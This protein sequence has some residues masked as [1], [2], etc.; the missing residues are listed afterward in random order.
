MS[1]RRSPAFWHNLHPHLAQHIHDPLDPPSKP[2]TLDILLAWTLPWAAEEPLR[3]GDMAR[4]MLAKNKS[5]IQGD[6]IGA[7]P[8]C[9]GLPQKQVSSSTPAHDE[10]MLHKFDNQL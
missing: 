2:P 6:R 5:D 9:L 3:R 7:L 10:M 1:P 4:L 8:L